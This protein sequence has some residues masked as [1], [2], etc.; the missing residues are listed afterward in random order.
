ME[1][2]LR[3]DIH[4]VESSFR[5]DLQSVENTLRSEITSVRTEIQDLET[6]LTERILGITHDMETRIL[7]AFY[8]YAQTND[9]RLLL[10]EGA[11]ANM[12]SRLGIVESRLLEIEERLNI[13]PGPSA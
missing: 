3:T 11:D 6:R 2:S 9:K 12:L 7:T 1:T 8:G 5:S 13:P 10:V 4:A